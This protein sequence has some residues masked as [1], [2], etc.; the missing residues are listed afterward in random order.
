MSN[1]YLTTVS[2]SEGKEKVLWHWSQ[3]GKG[4]AEEGETETAKTSNW[5]KGCTLLEIIQRFCARQVQIHVFDPGTLALW[6]WQPIPVPVFQF[7]L[8][9]SLYECLIHRSVCCICTWMVVWAM[10]DPYLNK[11][12]FYHVLTYL[13]VYIKMPYY[14][15]LLSPQKISKLGHRCL[16]DLLGVQIFCDTTLWIIDNDCEMGMYL[17]M[18]CLYLRV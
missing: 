14:T 2:A 15:W 13:V 3:R 9:R 11:Q 5:N 17:P 18:Y 8:S 4:V 7:P 6:T 16:T 1:T 12:Y 10:F